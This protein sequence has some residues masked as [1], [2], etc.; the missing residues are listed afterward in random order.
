MF[1]DGKSVGSRDSL[2][3]AHQHELTPS[4]APGPHLLTVCVDNNYQYRVGHDASSITDH[5]QTNWNGVIGN[6]RLIALNP[7]RFG[8][9]QAYPDFDRRSVRV[10]ARL[11]NDTDSARK[12]RWRLSAES[13]NTAICHRPAAVEVAVDVLPGESSAEAVLPLGP[14]AQTWDEF[15]PALY[16]LNSSLVTIAA[17]SPSPADESVRHELVFG[18]REVRTSGRAMLV[19]G[20][21]VFLRGTLDCGAFPLT[22]HPSMVLS[23][24]RRIFRVCKAYGLNHVR[25]HSWCPPR[26]A[27]EAADLEGMYLQVETPVWRGNCP[28]KDAPAVEPFLVEE[29]RRICEAFGNHPS[30]VLFAHGNEPW[31]LDHSW[32]I[33]HW[34]PMMKQ[35]DPRHLVTAGAHIPLGETSDF[36][37][38]GSWGGSGFNLRYHGQ[39]HHR[40]P[41]TIRN[42]EDQIATKPIPIISH[43]PGEWCVFPNLKETACYTGPLKP[44]NF[45]IVR[46][47][48]SQHNLLG[49]SEDFLHASG[50]FQ[51]EFYKEECEGFLRTRGLAGF[52]M[53]GL[54]DFPGQGTA[55]VGVVDAFWN[56][57]PYVTAQEFRKFCGPV[58]PLALMEKRV[59]SGDEIFKAVIRIA[60]YSNAALA[61][62]SISW[63]I[64]DEANCTIAKGKIPQTEIP[65]GNDL[66]LGQVSLPLSSVRKPSCLTLQVSLDGTS[67]ANDWKFWVFPQTSLP[68]D[69]GLLICHSADEAL[70]ALRDG[71]TVLLLPSQ[72]SIAAKTVGSFAPIFWNKAWFPGQ[73][74]HTLGLLIQ[75]QHPAIKGFPTSFH[76]DWQWWDLMNRSKPM[77]LD[78]LPSA[79]SPIIQPIDDWNTCRKLAL[80]FEVRVAAGKVMVCSID[81][82]TDLARRH[83]AREL[84][85]NILNYL[86]S[87][88]FQPGVEI[89]PADLQSLFTSSLAAK[90]IAKS[91]A[92]SAHRDHPA[93]LA[94]DGDP[95]TCWHSDWEA[96]PAGYPHEFRIELTRPT[97]ITGVN[98]LPR[99]DGSSNGWVADVEILI[100]QDGKRWTRSAASRLANNHEWKTVGFPPSLARFVTLRMLS[101]QSPTQPWASFAEIDLS[102]R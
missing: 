69:D 61:S 31:E 71:K 42:Y 88:R 47:F 64:T 21:P 82:E 85:R 76:A 45:E 15:S 35:L 25:Y 48:L 3:V 53:L 40:A 60:Q 100:S 55:L 99:S 75:H 43:E 95:A 70:P 58:V 65:I 52:Q 41:D 93:D 54:N 32:L 90:I 89:S 28:Y 34:V 26:P 86:R 91:S 96:S 7:I 74:E 14:A 9:V 63:N 78:A 79:L 1:F 92:S 10:V 27:F 83:E 18:L 37:L 5:T 77:V 73:R 51:V 19:N 98:L 94:L 36:H 4:A 22:G 49:Q 12:A 11:H 97:E 50:R 8:S 33:R 17:D 59:W 29:S 87:S 24:W 30:F 102:T 16:R 62:A 46:D 13:F 57:K 56:P 44:R 6:L 20:R 81:L 38:P 72:T 67:Y 23:D 84:R 80:A 66:D 2:C 68:E 39:V 101:P